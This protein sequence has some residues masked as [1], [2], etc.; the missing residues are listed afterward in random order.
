MKEIMVICY[1]AAAIGI[2]G[3]L[4]FVLWWPLASVIWRYWFG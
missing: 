4:G 1:A 2:F 3:V